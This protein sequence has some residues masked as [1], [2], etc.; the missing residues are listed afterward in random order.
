MCQLCYIGGFS[1]GDSGCCSVISTCLTPGQPNDMHGG[2]LEAVREKLQMRSQA[3]TGLRLT[4]VGWPWSHIFEAHR[5]G[6]C[7]RVL[8]LTGL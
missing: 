1:G 7:V 4:S 5:T 2:Q 6:W 3:Q 8:E